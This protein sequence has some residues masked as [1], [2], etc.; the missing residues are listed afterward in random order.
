MFRKSVS[1]EQPAFLGL[2]GGATGT[3]DG[4]FLGR[5]SESD[6]RVEGWIAPVME[7]AC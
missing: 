4:K 5:L 3:K 6:N 1:V 2:S 7:R